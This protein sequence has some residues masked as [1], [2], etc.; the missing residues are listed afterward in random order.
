LQF[1]RGWATLEG[2]QITRML[3][4]QIVGFTKSFQDWK[5]DRVS[6]EFKELGLDGLDLTV[7]KGGHIEPADVDQALPAAVNTA[8][9]QGLKIALLT[10]DITDADASAE[11]VLAAAAKLGIERI[12]LGYY[13]YAPF[14]TLARQMDDVRRRLAEVAKLG[15][16]HSVRPCVHIHSGADIPSHGTMLYQLI[17]D[18]SPE[19]IGAYVD[20]M[21]MTIE[22]GASGWQQGLDLLAPWISLV[23]IKNCAWEKTHRDPVG[24]QRWQTR[25]VPLAEG[26]APLPDFLAILKKIGYDGTYSLHSEYKGKHS[27]Q[28]LDTS[29]C[30]AQTA[31]DLAYLKRM[32]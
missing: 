25:V 11:K 5:L 22:G 30:L 3:A 29:Q 28:D 16:K 1:E 10:T 23:A 6:R 24:Q 2:S 17:R 7:R 31:Q 18:F 19:E 27:F 4:M 20:P 21:H 32:I 13:R 14:G 15:R 8:H 12:K 26:V 9:E